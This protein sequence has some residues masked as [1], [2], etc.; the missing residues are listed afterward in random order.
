M[1]KKNIRTKDLNINSITGIESF[2][3][4]VGVR[5]E[6]Y[7][8]QTRHLFKISNLVY[9][10]REIVLHVYSSNSKLQPARSIHTST[11]TEQ[12]KFS[13]LSLV[14]VKPVSPDFKIVADWL[15]C[16]THHKLLCWSVD[17]HFFVPSPYIS[18]RKLTVIYACTLREISKTRE[19]VHTSN[20]NLTTLRKWEPVELQYLKFY[21]WAYQ[22]VVK[23]KVQPIGNSKNI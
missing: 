17:I 15:K 21:L 16:A 13:C 22:E 2:S 20:D 14:Q 7:I 6:L 11:I 5:E 18:Q 8:R 4:L 12:I 9:S 10:G 19:G 3:P 1:Y 23:F